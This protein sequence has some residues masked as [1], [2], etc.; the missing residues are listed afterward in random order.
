[1]VQ[2]NSLVLVATMSISD[3]TCE[4]CEKSLGKKQSY[5]EHIRVVHGIPETYKCDVTDCAYE[6]KNQKLLRKHIS[7][8][9]KKEETSYKC[10][11]CPK[12]YATRQAFK[13]HIR[14]N[15]DS[16]FKGYPCDKC[17]FVGK[18]NSSLK[19]HLEFK[20]SPKMKDG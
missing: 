8:Y 13:N 15:H 19:Y 20:H 2:C 5:K 11:M 3:L 1:M 10:D 9:H 14:D 18:C 7:S 4:M 12:E 16:N 6:N 17:E